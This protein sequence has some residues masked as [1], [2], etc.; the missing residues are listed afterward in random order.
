MDQTNSYNSLIFGVVLAFGLSTCGYFVGQ[1]MY[2]AKAGVNTAEAKGLS[3]KRVKADKA[4]WTLV[5]KINGNKDA[6]IPNLYQQAEKDQETIINLLKEAG[7]D[8]KEIS[9]GVI[10]YTRQEFRNKD[11]A[12]VDEK[13]SLVGSIDIETDKV[14]LVSQVRAQVNKLIAKGLDLENRSPRYSFTKLNEIKPA[15]V[16]EAVQNARLAAEEFAS[17]AGVRVGHIESARQ[18]GFIIRDAGAEYGDSQKI[19]KDVRIV[20][21]ITFYLTN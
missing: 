10:D 8:A 14:D 7:F 21:T 19:E 13:H 18:G 12:L 9:A 11:N 20:T 5:F 3:E 4:N 15:M 1:T 6:N 16:K 17:N 2:N